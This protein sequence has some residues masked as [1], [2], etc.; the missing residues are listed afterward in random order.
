MFLVLKQR[1]FKKNLSFCC[2]IFCLKTF[3]FSFIK[4]IFPLPVD[5][6]LARLHPATKLVLIL[7]TC[8]VQRAVQVEVVSLELGDCEDL[9]LALVADR[10]DLLGE[11]V[12]G[13]ALG[14]FGLALCPTPRLAAGE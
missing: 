10:V 11:T 4:K 9:L 14:V 6:A 13:G 7:G 3:C 2:D 12:D 5:P 8:Q 1:C